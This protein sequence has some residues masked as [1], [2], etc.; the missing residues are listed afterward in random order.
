MTAT[1]LAK[2]YGYKSPWIGIGAYTVATATGMMRMANNKH[3]LSDVLTGAGIGIISTELGYYL[4]NLI[5]KEKGI[6][7]IKDEYAFDM[8]EKPSLIG[9]Y[10]GLNIPLTCGSSVV[11]TL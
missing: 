4:A 7:R 2:E 6:N 1:M 8:P 5:F 9:L 3:W 10:L 11:V